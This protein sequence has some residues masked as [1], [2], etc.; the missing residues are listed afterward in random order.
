MSYIT[1]WS[2]SDRNQIIIIKTT[3]ELNNIICRLLND[4]VNY[5]FSAEVQVQ[6]PQEQQKRAVGI[7]REHG[8]F[9]EGGDEQGGAAIIRFWIYLVLALIIIILAAIVI[10]MGMTS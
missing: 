3:L 4:N 9:R 6:V 10:N 5:F 2:T 7:L 8:F 1:V